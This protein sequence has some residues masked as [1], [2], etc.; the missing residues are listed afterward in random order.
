MVKRPYTA[1]ILAS[2]DLEA[3]GL[4]RQLEMAANKEKPIP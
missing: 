3:A 4:E 2:I 1:S